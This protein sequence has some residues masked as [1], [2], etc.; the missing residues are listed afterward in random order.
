M[1]PSH[2]PSLP[3]SLPSFP[4]WLSRLPVNADE[5]RQDLLRK[6]GTLWLEGWRQVCVC[7]CVRARAR[8]HDQVFECSCVRESGTLYTCAIAH[9]GACA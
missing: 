5:Q 1:H 6:D 4:L 7:V 8:E 9:M 2:S 3:P